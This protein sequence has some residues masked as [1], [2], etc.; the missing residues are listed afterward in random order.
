MRFGRRLGFGIAA[1][2]NWEL[3]FDLGTLDLLQA[4]FP[5][6][7]LP[8]V[9]RNVIAHELGHAVGLEHDHDPALLMCGRPAAC[10]PD[11]FTSVSPRI[12]PLSD[13]ERNRLLTLYP[14]SWTA[15]TR[16]QGPDE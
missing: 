15:R 6:L 3:R 13:D 2:S 14:R 11:A 8:N 1:S 4:R 9:P 7:T 16:N 12:F 10:R 5:T